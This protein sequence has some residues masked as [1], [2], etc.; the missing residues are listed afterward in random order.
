M[1][2]WGSVLNVQGDLGE[3]PAAIGADAFVIDGAVDGCGDGEGYGGVPDRCVV[4]HLG[5]AGKLFLIL[6]CSLNT[7]EGHLELCACLCVGGRL[8]IGKPW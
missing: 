5:V 1:L 4:G 3:F 2:R 6:C 7:Q 8:A